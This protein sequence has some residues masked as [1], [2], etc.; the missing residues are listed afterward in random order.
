MKMV[1]MCAIGLLLA[2]GASSEDSVCQAGEDCRTTGPSMVQLNRR[3]AKM[4]EQTRAK[5]IKVIVHYNN[6]EAKKAAQSAAADGN[7]KEL[8][9]MHSEILMVNETAF[10]GLMANKDLQVTEDKSVFMPSVHRMGKAYKIRVGDE[11]TPYGIH[12]VHADNVTQGSANIKVCVVDTGYH[13][14]HEDLPNESHQAI[15]G[16]N[17][18]SSGQ[19][20]IDGHSHG[21]HCAG[22]IGA[23]GGNQKGVTSPNPDPTKFTFY[24]GKGLNDAGS[25]SFSAVME[26]V[27]GCVEAGAKIISMSLGGGGYQASDAAEFKE[28]YEDHGVLIIAAAGNSGND[29]L[30]YPASYPHIMSVAAVD[31]NKERASFS[32]YNSQVEISGPGVE[33]R[34][35]VSINN[36]AS[37]YNE[38]AEYSGT[39]MAT[40]HVA[41]VAALVWSNF[42][43]CTN[44]EIR[45]VLLR[46]AEDLGDGGCDV[47]YGWGLVNAKL[48]Y[49]MLA[50]LGCAAG[51]KDQG[52]AGDENGGCAVGVVVPPT[53]APPPPTPAPPPTP[54]PTCDGTCASRRFQID[55]TTD[56]YASETDWTLADEEG[57][58]VMTGGNYEEPNT[59]Y[60]DQYACLGSGSYN[61]TIT[62]SYGDGIC[63]SYGNGGYVISVAGVVVAT[64]GDIGSEKTEIIEACEDGTPAPPPAADPTPSPTPAPTDDSG[65]PQGPA[66]PP[67]PPGLSGPPGPPGMVR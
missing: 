32:Q 67:G 23:I 24:I 37:I 43:L 57:N 27:N 45:R 46:S 16:I 42:P 36:G 59:E 49:D 7:V 29:A 58:E 5:T 9:T 12:L 11:Q 18:Y 52:F 26:A 66:G 28:V 63:C 34:S 64:G 40:P 56:N 53:P 55:L 21:T 61:F 47:N 13:L 50:Q 25:G 65:P 15:D 33:V 48:A 39:S 3:N 51:E 10:Q 38:Y 60:Y 1:L 20:Y 41:G 6:E 17:P 30:S 31:S 44:Q 8:S 54:Y 2:S 62:D 35:T 14:G 19:W 4:K 22:T